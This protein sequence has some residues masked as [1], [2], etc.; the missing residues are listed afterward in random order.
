MN[1]Y[2]LTLSKVFIFSKSHYLNFT[3]LYCSVSWMCVSFLWWLVLSWLCNN[4]L[5]V[6]RLRI[7]CKITTFVPVYS[8]DYNVFDV[9]IVVKSI[10]ELSCEWMLTITKTEEVKPFSKSCLW[11]GLCLVRHGNSKFSFSR[12]II[13]ILCIIALYPWWTFQIY[14][15]NYWAIRL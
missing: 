1:L 4:S 11:L 8:P 14:T 7:D 12:D 15:N 2:F 3:A 10:F 13:T 5:L 6:S 9:W